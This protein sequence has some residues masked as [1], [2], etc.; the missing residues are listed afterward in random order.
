MG[1]CFLSSE[2][3]A[4]GIIYSGHTILLKATENRRCIHDSRIRDV[5]TIMVSIYCHSVA[6]SPP[7]IL[8]FDSSCPPFV[9]I[10]TNRPPSIGRCLLKFIGVLVG[11]DA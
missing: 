8:C 2:S 3:Y 4:H 1:L 7:S 6:L 5:A 10:A 11:V 9:V